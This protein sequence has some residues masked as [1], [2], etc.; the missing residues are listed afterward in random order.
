MKNG[1]NIYDNNLFVSHNQFHI[2][3]K[4]QRDLET[5]LTNFLF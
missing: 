5:K 2:D 4:V 3:I 1:N